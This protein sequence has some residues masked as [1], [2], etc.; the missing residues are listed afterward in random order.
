M[1][2]A[3]YSVEIFSIQLSNYN[4]LFNEVPSWWSHFGQSRAVAVPTIPILVYNAS[5]MLGL[6]HVAS[7]DWNLATCE[8][9]SLVMC[10]FW[11]FSRTAVVD[12]FAHDQRLRLYINRKIGILHLHS[13]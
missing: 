3:W 13:S 1:F 9:C 6:A 2:V 4:Q 5:R 10:A 12:A 8:M 11:E 7:D